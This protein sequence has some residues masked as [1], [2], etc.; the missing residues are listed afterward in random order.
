MTPIE[1]NIAIII[2]AAGASRRLGSPKQLLKWGSSTLLSHAMKTA[3]ELD[4]KEIVVVLGAHYDKIRSEIDD[5]S[6]QILKNEDWKKGLGSSIAVGVEY[7]LNAKDDYDAVLIMLA[8]QP[9]ITALYLK[10]M[11][12]KFKVDQNQ[13]VTTG[14]E[15]GKHGVPAVFGKKYFNDLSAL[16]G[17][18]GA[19]EL[20]KKSASFVTSIGITPAI[21]DVDTEEDYNKIYKAN[22]L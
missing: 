15:N 3:E 22:H 8:D 17:D 13:I 9:L 11:I 2:P 4:Q 18:H 1:S 10:A 14:Y 16:T 21:S 6:I 12:E 5:N 7:L 20:I 19:G